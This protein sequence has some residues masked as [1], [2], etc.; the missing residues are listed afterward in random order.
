MY[1]YFRRFAKFEDGV[2]AFYVIVIFRIY[3]FTCLFILIQYPLNV[4]CHNGNGYTEFQNV[5]F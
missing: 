3:L 5:Q 2:S 4:K 1:E